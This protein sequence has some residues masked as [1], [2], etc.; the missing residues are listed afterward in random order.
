V[1]T[2]EGTEEIHALALGQALTGMSAYR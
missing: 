2:Y 1:I